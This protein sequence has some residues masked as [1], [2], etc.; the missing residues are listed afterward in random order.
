MGCRLVIWVERAAARVSPRYDVVACLLQGV[1]EL[2]V[3]LGGVPCARDENDRGVSR[4]LHWDGSREK[5][6]N[7]DGEESE[8]GKDSHD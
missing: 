8:K 7:G 3:M 2:G 4:I 5:A 1:C 6:R